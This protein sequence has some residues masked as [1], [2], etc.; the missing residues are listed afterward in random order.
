MIVVV[1]VGVILIVINLVT[2]GSLISE[3]ESYLSEVQ[4]IIWI[5]IFIMEWSKRL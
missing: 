2:I 5:T 3:K 1:I 4:V